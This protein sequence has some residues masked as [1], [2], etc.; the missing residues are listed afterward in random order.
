MTRFTVDNNN[1]NNND[2][3]KPLLF[4]I[5]NECK[6]FPKL[7]ISDNNSNNNNSC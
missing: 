3:N 5:M 1:D 7:Y 4:I 6:T 2:N